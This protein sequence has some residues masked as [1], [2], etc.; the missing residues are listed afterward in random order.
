MRLLEP[1]TALA[2]SE[3]PQ[4]GNATAGVPGPVRH[5]PA[6]QYYPL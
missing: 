3:L 1:A 5:R 4:L 2:V 6:A